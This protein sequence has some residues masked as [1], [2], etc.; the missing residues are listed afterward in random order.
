ML[1]YTHAVLDLDMDSALRKVHSSSVSTFLVVL[2]ILALRKVQ[3]RSLSFLDM[4]LTSSSLA[5][6]IVLDTFFPLKLSLN[7]VHSSSV[8]TKLRIHV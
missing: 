2:F 4:Y 5:S 3:S 6:R 8:S 7:R 1:S